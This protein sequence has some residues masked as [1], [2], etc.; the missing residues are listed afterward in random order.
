LVFVLT[1]WTSVRETIGVLYFS[2][3]K[4]KWGWV[5]YTFL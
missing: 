1:N 3:G 4:V 2:F 5:D